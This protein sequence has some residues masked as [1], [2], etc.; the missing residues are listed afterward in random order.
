[1]RIRRAVLVLSGLCSLLAVPPCRAAAPYP[2]AGVTIMTEGLSSGSGAGDVS[3]AEL[4]SAFAAEGLPRVLPIGGLDPIANTRDLLHLRGIDMAV[5]NAD[6][7]AYA[8]LEGGLGP[9][10]RRLRSVVKL[11]DKGIYVVAR[12]E[13][14]SIDGLKGKTVLALGRDSES[15]VSARTLFALLKIDVKLSLM[16]LEASIAALQTGTA[17]AVVL[18]AGP[19]DAA[20]LQRLPQD[21]GLHVLGIP[22]KDALAQV[23]G[24]A[25]LAP[26]LAPALL[27]DGPVETV[28]VASLLATY[29]W[30]ATDF[31]YA[32]VVQ[33]LAGVPQ[34]VERLRAGPHRAEWQG[35]SASGQIPGW[36]A[37][38]PVSRM[39]A[40][41]TAGTSAPR[42]APGALPS[43][44]VPPPH[45]ALPPPPTLE[46]PVELIGI[47]IPGLADASAQGGGMLTEILTTA[48]GGDKR[49]R[50]SLAWSA[51][52]DD[53]EARLQQTGGTHRIGFAAE[54]PDCE[55]AAAGND[56]DAKR[57]AG[58][59]FS[60]PL[61]QTLQ[62]FFTRSGSDFAFER[63]EQVAGHT[64][65]AA[66]G[67]DLAALDAGGRNWVKDEVLTLLKADSLERCLTMVDKGEADA[68][69]ADEI[70]GRA[71]VER[72][73]LSERVVVVDRPVATRSLSAIAA[74]S[75]PD[76]DNLIAAVDG[77]LAALQASGG[78][79][80]IISRRLS[81]RRVTERAATSAN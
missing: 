18:L 65:C 80:E 54:A 3:I 81:E 39:L 63:D 38:E 28:S 9:I 52:A 79:Y 5:V 7:L 61:F 23:Y 34:A 45:P 32:A 35:V 71:E 62:L 67:S 59:L 24:R 57:C 31:R 13:I 40:S 73:G 75:D 66:P 64:V 29:N 27:P 68:A 51:G 16:S 55:H 25:V 4:A 50:L 11:T 58:F 69:F 56:A 47:P 37:F 72:L 33:F 41:L 42:Q 43:A 53:A 36:Q 60:H 26:E 6:I 44:V 70:A 21:I 19:S 17:D 49:A 1:M 78:Y 30:R 22:T 20:P 10:D 15:H 14:A 48:L 74:R 2:D 8:R 77:G 12:K 76:A 46:G